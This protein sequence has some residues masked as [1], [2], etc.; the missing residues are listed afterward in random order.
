[1]SKRNS[2]L[3]GIV[4]AADTQEQA[5]DHFRA[6]ASGNYQTLESKDGQYAFA[7]SDT[8]GIQ[9]MNPL[10]GEEMVVVPED[11]KH[12][13]VATASAGSDMDVFYK[14]C[15]SGCG[16]HVIADQEE[17]L[18]QCPS[19]ASA[20]PPME[21]AELKNTPAQPVKEILLAVASSRKEAA[22]AYKALASGDCETFTAECD[23]VKV[24]SNQPLTYDIYKG[25]PAVA[26]D[27]YVPQLAVAANAEGKIQAHYLTT[28]ATEGTDEQL[29]LICSDES[30]IFCPATSS[31]LVDPI[32]A[33]TEQERAVAAS[34]FEDEEEEEEDDEEESEDDEEDDE[35][36]EEDD[37][38]EDEDD[39]DE[40]EEEEDDEDLSLS[41]ASE[42][43]AKSKTK[44]GGVRRKSKEKK[45]VATASSTPAAPAVAPVV[46]PT[47]QTPAETVPLT[48]S[49]VAIASAANAMTDTSVEV[50]Y[51][52]S[53]QGDSTWLAFHDGVPFAKAT[54]SNAEN[55]TQFADAS[56]GRAFKALAS[57]QGVQ[58]A[59]E[60]M[61]FEEIRPVVNVDQLVAAQIETRVQE[62]T[63]EIA[64]AATRDTEELAQ[65]FE[66]AIATAAQGI[67]RGFFPD[68]KNP[69]R[70]ALASTLESLGFEG[71]DELLQR[72]FA[73]HADDHHKQILA[74]A[75]E[76]MKF[77][78]TVQ[79]QLATAINDVQEVSVATAA[80]MSIGR[81]VSQP[82]KP[83]VKP[84]QEIATAAS[85]PTDFAAKL[86]T[87]RF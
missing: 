47:V 38:D 58:A 20:L 77:D 63:A 52:G 65:R 3:R 42:K 13:M 33:M 45:E 16:S 85:V 71:G 49:L 78:L 34:D 5:L 55:P 40:E 39:E 4:V 27:G 44:K 56:F 32:E 46:E 83:H 70:L 1:M 74:K 15:A 2:Q 66:A 10:N 9:I 19:C 72:A 53:V 61:K 54:A 25:T 73:D 43:P 14:V 79:N 30:P 26:V 22:V 69:V 31:G 75:C 8:V 59:M 23:G 48:A 37:E 6:V 7:T 29:H 24:I 36:E 62:A 81:P 18:M 64:Q 60:Q 80:S 17:I 28:A 12:D 82:V 50:A 51:V 87:L 84:E 57:E 68:L 35:E 21:D 76:I 67:N 11:E 41:L 86:A